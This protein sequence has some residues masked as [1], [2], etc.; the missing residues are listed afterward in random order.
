MTD[1][2]RGV[3]PR[4]AAALLLVWA[5]AWS[6]PAGRISEDTKNDL[7]VAPWGFLA[8]AA[9]LWDPQ[10]TWGVLQNQ[11]YGYLFP[12]GPFFGLVGE[13]VPVWVAQRLWWG[14]LLSVGLLTTYALLSALR[15]GGPTARVLGALAYTLSPR[16]L[17]TIGGLSSEA[18]PVLLAPAILLP[19]VLATQGRI[20]PR[21][22][23]ALSG[24]AVLCCGGV[25]ASATILAAVPTGLWLLTRRRWWRSS[26][27]W[28]WAG[29]MVAASAWW[30]GPLAVLG[31]WSPPFLDWI[32]R[33]ADVVREIDL[34]DVARGT[35]H[36]LEFVVT[37]GG[38]WWPAGYDLATSAALVVAT[39]L[40]A[41]TALAGLGLRGVAER[42]F[43]LL[44]LAVGVFLL[45]VAH[46]GPVSSPLA[47]TAQA[48]LD[49]P[50]VAFRNIH[51]ADPL[52]RL[53]LAVGLAQALDRLGR[54]LAGRRFGIR[55][56]SWAAALVVVLVAVSPGLS[57]AIAPRGTFPDMARQWRQAGEWLTDRAADGRALVVPAS[58]FGEYDWGRTIDEPI[59]PLSDVAYAVRDAVPLTP[60]GTTRVLDA[61]EQRLQTGRDVGGAVDVLRRVGVRYLVLRNDLDTA[62]A[63]Q[64]SVT[65]ARSAI[66]STPRISLAKGFGLTRID[67]SG[68]RVFPVEVYDLGTAAPLAVTQPVADVVAV[69][70]GPEDLLAVADTGAT[71]LAVL[72]GD[73]VAGVDP[74]HRVVTDG[75]R[76]RER[77]FGATR[78]RDTSSTLTE[79]QL[80]D[81]R[82]YR[83]WPDLDRH[84][85]TEL[86]GVAGV[87]ASSS[88]ATDLTLAGLRPADRPSAV[89]DADPTTAWVTQFDPAPTVEVRLDEARRLDAARIQVVTDRDRFP[90]LGVPTE[91]A[92]RTDAGEARVDVPKSG[93]VEVRLPDGVTDS[94]AVEVL[95]TDRGRPAKVLTGLATVGLDDIVVNESVVGPGDRAE[96]ADE[97]LLSGGLPGTDGCVQPEGK[98]VC[99]GEGSR[100]PEGGAVLSRRFTAAGGEEYATTGTL[101]ASQWA[102][103]IPGLAA[104]GV[105][106]QTSS[107]RSRA[108]SARPEVLVDG[109]DRTA[110]SP[111]AD[112][113]SP[114]I[115]VTLDEPADVDAVVLHA[116]RGWF[117]R[118][119][120][121]VRVSLDGREEEVVR[122]SPDGRLAVRGRGVEN[123]SVTVLPLPGRQRTA[124]AAL[125]VEELELAGHD[126][127]R[128]A[129]RVTRPCGDGPALEVDGTTVP[130]RLDGPRS[131]L[132]GEGDLAWAACGPTRLGPGET[133]EVVVRGDEA[134]R[135]ATVRLARV[136]ATAPASLPTAV[137]MTT[138][139]PT[140]LTGSVAAGPQRLLALAMNHNGGWQATLAG[141]PLTPIVVDGFR[142]GFV[143][144][145]GA[146]GPLD[147]V[148]EPD[149]AYRV[150][151]GLGLVLA[152]LLL[153]ALVLPEPGRRATPAAGDPDGSPRVAVVAV[154]TVTFAFVLA[155]PW[156][157][158]AAALALGLLRLRRS[159]A[160]APVAVAVVVLVGGSGVLVALTDPAA[161]TRSWVEA[162][163]TLAVIAAGVLAGG[164]PFVPPSAWPGAR[165]R[166]GSA[167]PGTG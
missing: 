141:A 158:L 155:G 18:L 52:V 14:L 128:P 150:A 65:Y 70:G 108:V 81:T 67:A 97:V 51:K 16:V 53:P 136:D 84:S 119:R 17:S 124:A 29:G 88:L 42:R 82:D 73:R 99:F 79:E 135:P 25:N 59:R 95:D 126:L 30:L 165:R 145:D 39:A 107:S 41:G 40:L 54:A 10:V 44:T 7:Y 125:E 83:P 111:A 49:G 106:V 154:A 8:R 138:K 121:F 122:A 69:S 1:A 113:T 72:D 11:G 112:D 102:A 87:A 38:E 148:F 75:Y 130:T 2:V 167:T 133:H 161:P 62:S 140:H 27:T 47:P 71:G 24:L 20:G 118:Y 61:V 127:A 166:R 147:V 143:L 12:M 100:D 37:S 157:A 35:T 15:A 80:A 117:A 9:H 36:W 26:V 66:R 5:V 60:A 28:W 23:A 45:S 85:V 3:R 57:G 134:V 22:A 89:L 151:L 137:P 142:Q 58:S 74:T 139:T 105:S 120:P 96:V 21:R 132:W 114:N 6:V 131:A 94:V 159:A 156:A 68:E 144:P 63:G 93:L 78:G 115:T 50:L 164:A 55:F 91:L 4:L 76:G 146:S 98:V 103:S 90:G 19:V 160:D 64:P 13:V 109:D 92:V 152:L 123:I 33:S 153:V 104:P 31:T 162:T 110:W 163:V 86:D 149:G 34:L 56:G 129:A 46:V 116:R 101:V 48:L 32:E 43:L 77:W